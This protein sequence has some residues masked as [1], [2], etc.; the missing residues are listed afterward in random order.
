MVPSG[1]ANYEPSSLD[2]AAKTAVRREC[3]ATGFV[4]F[5]ANEER[6]DA[7]E[8]LRIRPELFADHYSQARLFF[9]SQQPIEQA[10]IASALVFGLPK[11]ALLAMRNRVMSRLRNIDEDLAKRVA[12]GLAMP[13]GRSPRKLQGERRHGS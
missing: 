6:N 13:E 12:A 1:R 11:V 4:T 8:K 10:H 3:P 5:P 2:E 7:S 9:C